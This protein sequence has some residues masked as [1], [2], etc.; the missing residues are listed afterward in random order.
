[1]TRV[2]C[3]G[4]WCVI[5]SARGKERMKK[6]PTRADGEPDNGVEM[7]RFP[8]LKIDADLPK[9]SKAAAK[10]QRARRKKKA[11][12][13]AQPNLLLTQLYYSAPHPP[14]CSLSPPPLRFSC[15]N[16]RFQVCV[17]VCV[18]V[19]VCVCVCVEN[20]PGRAKVRDHTHIGTFSLSLS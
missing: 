13:N 18:R 3:S 6:H 20:G 14:S 1:M 7:A 12:D 15:P 16:Q 8:H 5:E 11:H 17:N 4:L 19:R 9:N 10:R 2:G